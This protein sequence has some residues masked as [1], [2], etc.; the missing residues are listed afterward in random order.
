VVEFASLVFIAAASTAGSCA[1]GEPP[2]IAPEP[3]P[4]SAT[5]VVIFNYTYKPLTLTV[6]VGTTVTW[7][8]KDLAPHTV[9]HRAYGKDNFDSG[10]MLNAQKFTRTFRRAGTFDYICALHQGMQGT[11]VVKDSTATDSTAHH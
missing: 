9:T 6:P 1:G 3:K 5:E 2:V 8:N 11:V 4:T 7:V 10:N